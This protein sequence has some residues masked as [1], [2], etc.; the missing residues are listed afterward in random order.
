[1]LLDIQKNYIGTK[2]SNNRKK[3]S[4]TNLSSIDLYLTGLCILGDKLL[5]INFLVYALGVYLAIRILLQSPDNTFAL[6]IF[7]IP[8]L[9][10]M[11]IPIPGSP[12]PL[13]NMLMGLA[14]VKVVIFYYKKPINKSYLIIVGTFIVYEWCHIF[15]YDLKSIMLLISWSTAVLYV[16][17]YFINSLKTYNHKTVIKY[18]ITG[19]IIS[20]LFGI[21][22]FY[23]KYGTLMTNNTTIR[24][25]GGAGDP[26][27]FSMY[28]I[29]AMFIMLYLVNQKSNKFLLFL[30]SLLFV[31]FVSFGVLSLS[32][33]FLLVV[34]LLS[35][36]LILKI[37][38]EIKRYKKIVFFVFC[39]S[40][41]FVLFSLFYI[42]EFASILNLLFSRFTDFT[43]DPS[44]LTSNRNV[45]AEQY[46][47]L[48]IANTKDMIFGLGIQEYYLRSGAI[49]LEAHNIILEILVVWGIV[50]FLI[51]TMFVVVL[52]KYGNS[53]RRFL[54][55]SFISLVPIICMGISYMS[56][57]AM[58]NESFF[59]LLLFAIKNIHEFDL[60]NNLLKK[61]KHDNVSVKNQ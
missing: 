33:M 26:N 49:Q 54:N 51:F 30:Y 4:R 43:N 60:P 28:I 53:K 56:L 20:I 36:L 44:G 31:F 9:A 45:L 29:I 34:V 23:G 24:F 39:I 46:I 17:L 27:Y 61:N 48:L 58:S 5:N 16:S 10:I 25:K 55:N 6:L 37:L 52:F 38:F 40:I 15:Y 21:L 59:L 12:V 41:I 35:A 42:E 8:N 13:L 2:S 11:F 22:D 19:V 1:M 47:Q 18:F 7:L 14:L 57:N 50:G 32:R 3:A